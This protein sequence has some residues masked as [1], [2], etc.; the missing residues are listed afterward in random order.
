MTPTQLDHL[1][2]ATATPGADADAFAARTGV[3][4]SLGGRH[5]ALGTANHLLGL[6]GTDRYV[7]LIHPDETSEVDTPLARRLATLERNGLCH[8]ALRSPELAAVHSR[9]LAAGIEST[10]PLP[11]SRKTPE[12]ATL[13]WELLFLG[14]HGHGGLVPFFID[15]HDTPHPARGLAPAASI[16]DFALESPDADALAD[17]LAR[18]GVDVFVAPARQ[19]GFRIRLEAGTS[20]WDLETA[21]PFGTGLSPLP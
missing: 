2:W 17:L 8:W 15:W 10:G 14:G 16:K 4:A 6:A 20:T 9:A 18:L 11:F 21:A 13:E 5:E 12:G 7:E 19:P 1:V 3:H